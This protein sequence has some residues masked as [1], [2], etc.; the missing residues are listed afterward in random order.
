MLLSELSKDYLA[1]QSALKN[2]CSS[3]YGASFHDL[4]LAQQWLH[5]PLLDV[6]MVRHNAAHRSAQTRVFNHLD[7]QDPRRPGIVTLLFSYRSPWDAPAELLDTCWRPSVPDRYSLSQN[8]VDVCLMGLQRNWCC[9]R[10]TQRG[11]SLLLNLTISTFMAICIAI[12]WKSKTSHL[13]NCFTDRW[14]HQPNKLFSRENRVMTEM[15]ATELQSVRMSALPEI[16]C[17]EWRCILLRHSYKIWNCCSGWTWS[18]G[19]VSRSARYFYFWSGI[20]SGRKCISPR[21]Q[22]ARSFRNSR[23]AFSSK[24]L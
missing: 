2:G 13:N 21:A 3:L 1:P 10:W 22:V 18:P 23:M 8:C 15:S 11:N 6:V 16:S 9:D 7:A 14:K 24:S 5:S 12:S 17:N 4:A 20:T 19:F